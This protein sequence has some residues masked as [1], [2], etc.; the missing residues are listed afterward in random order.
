MSSSA[1]QAETKTM[2]DFRPFQAW[3][4]D[5]SAIDMNR[6]IAPPYDVISPSE[7]DDLY[8]RSPYNCIRLILN[9]IETS[10][11]ES[12]NRYSRANKFYKAWQGEKI[13]VQ[14]EQPSYYLYRQ[15]FK[16]PRSGK[17]ADRTAILGKLHLEPFENEIVIPHEKT[18][19]KPRADRRKLL[20]ATETNFSPV[21]G[22]YEDPK[23]DVSAIRH[24]ITKT[25]PLFEALDDQ[26][27]RHSVW[28]VNKTE[29]VKRIQSGMKSRKIY[30]ADGHHRYQTALEY[31]AE[32]RKQD[33]N[34]ESEMPYDFVLMALIEFND[35]G[36]ILLPTHRMIL[37][38]AG[39]D[40][41]TALKALA[42]KALEPYFKLE[43]MAFEDL[44]KRLA[45]PEIP[46]K[47]ELGLILGD[48]NYLMTLENT[49]EA[50]K[51]MIQGKPDVWYGLDVNLL[52]HLVFKLWNIDESM[53]ETVLRFTKHDEEAASNVQSGQAK[54][55][56]LLRAPQVSILREMGNVREL[57]PQK[58]TY[59]HPKLASG[60]VFYSH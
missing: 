51:K 25:S 20:E 8:A 54:A 31:G 15:T 45:R 35:P 23:G 33:G 7:Q 48:K 46:A 44:S 58:S 27:V 10:D 52:A 57:M 39:F 42:L 28:V 16:D 18:L 3:R 55:A 9:K 49:A 60:L 32:K 22:L 11:N 17:T 2:T 38:Y 50:R 19:S 53:W 47:P 21:F 37:P 14:E 29:W 6:V 41:P 5:P 13:L 56:F 36:L 59:F 24:E 4:Y 26:G 30:I 1:I 40:A 12:Q 43:P 34:P